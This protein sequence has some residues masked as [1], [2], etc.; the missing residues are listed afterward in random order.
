MVSRTH[1]I[2]FPTTSATSPSQSTTATHATK[3]NYH[4]PA[5]HSQRLESMYLSKHSKS[6]SFHPKRLSN[7]AKQPR[8]LDKNA[9]YHER[10]AEVVGAM[11]RHQ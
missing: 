2:F 7:P 11:F 5:G 6:P 8:E 9:L 4:F 10:E 3:A 1:S